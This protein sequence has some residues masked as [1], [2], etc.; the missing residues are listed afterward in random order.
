MLGRRTD[1]RRSALNQRVTEATEARDATAS[2]PHLPTSC[3][4]LRKRMGTI[5]RDVNIHASPLQHSSH[6]YEWCGS[7]RKILS[8]ARAALI[9]DRS[10]TRST[11]HHCIA[12][13]MTSHSDF[14]SESSL[15]T[16]PVYFPSSPPIVKQTDEP[17]QGDMDNTT[18]MKSESPATQPDIPAKPPMGRVS[19]EEAERP[20]SAQQCQRDTEEHTDENG[21]EEGEDDLDSDP[22]ERIADFD[23][24][25]LHQR[26][27]NAMQGCHDQEGELAQE[28]E[29]LMNVQTLCY[30]RRLRC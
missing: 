11:D 18:R 21:E 9:V 15:P 22:A 8:R 24:T 17:S 7:R 12:S 5:A 29:S 2:Q 4:A 28:W 16:Q 13:R 30:M 20:P 27:H 10:L 26:Y 1:C 19:S 6:L 3:R 25:D 14:E 23:W